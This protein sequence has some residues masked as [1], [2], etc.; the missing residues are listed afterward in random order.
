[1]EFKIDGGPFRGCYSNAPEDPVAQLRNAIASEGLDAPERI[2]ID[3]K[4]HR[5][6]S[7]AKDKQKSGWYIAY[8]DAAI[9]AG[10]FGCWKNGIDKK[11]RAQLTRPLSDYELLGIREKQEKAETA[12]NELLA[13]E[14]IASVTAVEAIWA[15]SMPADSNHPYLIKKSIDANGAKITGDGRLVVPLYDIDG[16]LSSLQ[17]I[18]YDGEKRYHS[19]GETKGKLW[20]VGNIVDSETIYIAEGFA[21]ACSIARSTGS[22]CIIAYSASNLLPV[23]EKITQYF[24]DKKIVI[25]AD[26]DASGIGEKYAEQ[27]SAKFGIEYIVMPEAG[28]ANDFEKSGGDLN[29]L[30]SRKQ[31]HDSW[32][33]RADDYC[34]QPAPIK[35]LIKNWLQD[36]A[37][38]MIHGPS[39]GGKTFCVLDMCCTIASDK[40]AWNGL[41]AASGEVVYLAG[42]GHAGLR[43]RV[44]A[45][46]QHNQV[47]NL[48]LWLSRDGCDLDKNEGYVKIVSNLKTNQIKPRLIVVDTLHRFMSG[49]EN[50]AQDT[51]K[52]LDSCSRLQHEF[53]CSVILVHHTGASEEQQHRAR[54]SSAWRGALDIEIS[55]VPSKT[56]KTIKI[57]QKKSKDAEL[58]E[59]KIMSLE[60]V[61]LDGWLD[62]DGEQVFS[63]VITESVSFSDDPDQDFYFKPMAE[64]YANKEEA[65]IDASGAF[66]AVA[67]LDRVK[68]QNG[69]YVTNDAL[70]RYLAMTY[71]LSDKKAD[72]HTKNASF[73]SIA[74]LLQS[75][76]KISQYKDG[77]LI[78]SHQLIDLIDS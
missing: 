16:T 44:K 1:M 25:V 35:W 60:K 66:V 53:N 45:W 56:D 49:D 14:K 20:S 34:E 43:G 39:G 42:E 74:R 47:E 9:P 27:A 77:W 62:E 13:A 24:L 36:N 64:K 3:G 73:A 28:D 37:L 30:L 51:K 26:N 67:K 29:A 52:I 22:G 54:G 4:I 17:Y 2:W 72:M 7:G 11:W 15:S 18:S 33:V 55:V 23:S 32:L 40:T 78:T 68:H 71:R 57:S 19:G 75:Q 46:K 21:T 59:D 10:A 6:K 76:N 69:Y 31:P 63:A 38:I 48:N 41:K 58:A 50:S 61:A 5:F 8:N 65:K 12:R 70:K